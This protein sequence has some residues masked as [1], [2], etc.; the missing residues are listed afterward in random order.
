MRGSVVQEGRPLLR[1]DRARPRSG[2]RAASPEVA[3]RLPHQARGRAGAGRPALEVRPR[4]VRRAVAPDA[5][6]V[7]RRSGCEAI[8]PTVRPSTFDS[9]SRN[10]RNH[11]IDHIGS[12]RLTKVDAGVLNGLYALLLAVGPAAAVAERARATRLRSSSARCELRADG[13]TL[14]ATAERLRAEFAEAD[15]IT[16]D[17]LASLLRRAGERRRRTTAPTRPRPADGQ[18][19][20]HDPAPRL[21]GRRP[22]G[23]ARSEPGRRRRPAARRP[24]V[25]RR[26]RLGRADAARVPRRVVGGRR[27]T[28]PAVGAARHDRDAARRGARAALVRRRPRRRP[29]ARRA[30]DHP[31]RAAR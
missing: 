31:D 15:H 7:P 9:Y 17:T 23:P 21:Q 2:H 5:R 25:R 28:A 24:E 4:R 12:T 27:S 29:A 20:P 26:P 14:A 22:L 18:L 3:L 11:V 10:M 19:R 8:E 30:D 16:K 1:Q 6:R 13:L